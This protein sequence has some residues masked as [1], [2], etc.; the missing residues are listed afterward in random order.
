MSVT[1]TITPTPSTTPLICGSGVT[2]GNFY[3]T[4]CCGNFVQGN[5][6]G[7]QFSID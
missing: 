4:D 3:Y 5:Q 7:L 1:P 2:T 6:V